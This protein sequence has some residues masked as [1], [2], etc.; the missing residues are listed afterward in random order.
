MLIDVPCVICFDC[1][2]P[3][4]HTQQARFER[5]FTLRFDTDDT[6]APAQWVNRYPPKPG[7]KFYTDESCVIFDMMP[8]GA[9][10]AM[11]QRA[12]RNPVDYCAD[13]AEGEV[14]QKALD[15]EREEERRAGA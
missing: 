6:D 7:D 5:K 3:R 8:E 9:D 1:E 15:E 12:A 14:L 11:K 2:D 13:P 4:A 10:K